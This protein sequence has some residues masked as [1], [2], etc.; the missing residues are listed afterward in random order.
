MT[1]N[2]AGYVENKQPAQN[3][4]FNFLQCWIIGEELTHLEM[5]TATILE[6]KK[7]RL[8]IEN[9]NGNI[10]ISKYCEMIQ[11]KSPLCSHSAGGLQFGAKLRN[12][13]VQKWF[14]GL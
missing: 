3:G 11:N 8:K 13:N 5:M 9:F 1:W 4:R 14:I 2:F 6:I 12:L 10:S 7:L